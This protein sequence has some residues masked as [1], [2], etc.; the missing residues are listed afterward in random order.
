M[1]AS[2]IPWT[3]EETQTT[4]SHKLPTT[5]NYLQLIGREVLKS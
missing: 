1:I 4:M 3:D 2:V 5:V